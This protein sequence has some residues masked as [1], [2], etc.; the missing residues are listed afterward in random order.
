[1]LTAPDGQRNQ[2]LWEAARN[3]YN[4]VATGALQDREVYQGLLQA[5][6]RC[7]LL[8]DEPARPMAPW[9]RAA[10]SAWPTPTR[11][12]SSAPPIPSPPPATGS[13]PSTG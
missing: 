11:L 3:L 4:L 2:R 6:E 5:A 12:C 10:T 7:G 8:T 9:P 1:M 13:R